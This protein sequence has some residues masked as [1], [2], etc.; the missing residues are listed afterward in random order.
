MKARAAV[1]LGLCGSASLATLAACRGVIGIEQLELVDAAAGQ[2][3]G[4]QP[5]KDGSPAADAAQ[6]SPSSLD[7]PTGM[8]A[9][10]A[11]AGP[12][13]SQM[14]GEACFACCRQA[15]MQGAQAYTMFAGM[16]GSQGSCLCGATGECQDACAS[17]VCSG[18]GGM[19]MPTMD[20]NGCMDLALF[21]DAGSPDPQ[22]TSALQ[23]CEDSGPCSALA[24]CMRTCSWP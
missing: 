10:M 16:P 12:G 21:P 6:D 13:C 17:S 7:A 19:P 2:P 5:Q 14:P 1:L 24:A 18:T 3:E 22:C 23:E 20:C 15:N 11:E 9:P 4:G 8:D